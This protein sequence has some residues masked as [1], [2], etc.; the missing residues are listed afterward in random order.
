VPLGA[1]GGPLEVESSRPLGAVWLLDGLW[2]Q[3]GM[4]AALARQGRYQHVR[5]NL[6]VKEVRLGSDP[7]GVG[8]SATTPSEAGRDAK[9][10]DDR[11][12]AITEELERIAAARAADA[13]RPRTRPP[14]TASDEPL[15]PARSKHASRPAGQEVRRVPLPPDEGWS[16]PWTTVP[17]AFGGERPSQRHP[18]LSVGGFH[19]RPPQVLLDVGVRAP[20]RRAGLL[21]QSLRRHDCRM[22][23]AHRPS[24]GLLTEVDHA[25]SLSDGGVGTACRLGSP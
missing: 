23:V 3:L 5:D 2:K 21:V 1:Q 8:S 7:V 16:R 11:L 13:T 17:V 25:M 10:R 14:A 18:G 9:R 19:F 4:D 22:G 24:P 15:R 20:S 6:R 12:T